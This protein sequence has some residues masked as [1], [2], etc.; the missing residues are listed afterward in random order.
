MGDLN[1]NLMKPSQKPYVNY[2]RVI[3]TK[4]VLSGSIRR[5][6]KKKPVELPDN[7]KWCNNQ[8]TL[9]Q[10]AKVLIVNIRRSELDK[11]AALNACVIQ[12][13]KAK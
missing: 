3:K 13:D 5:E 12:V 9:T 6:A 7:V 1:W 4:P 11:S 10:D 8:S 2:G